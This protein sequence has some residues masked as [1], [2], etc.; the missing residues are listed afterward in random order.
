[1][2]LPPPQQGVTR[3]QGEILKL[4]FV[5]TNIILRFSHIKWK[6]SLTKNSVIGGAY[7]SY[8]IYTRTKFCGQ[9]NKFVWDHLIITEKPAWRDSNFHD[10][11]KVNIL[12]RSV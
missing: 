5:E 3:M 12:T 6:K 1:M 9:A 10:I 2:F 7:K 4:K 8:D 11:S